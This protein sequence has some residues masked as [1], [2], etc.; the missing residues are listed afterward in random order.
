MSYQNSILFDSSNLYLLR[1]QS[2]IKGP[3]SLSGDFSW[4][5]AFWEVNEL[6]REDRVLI[7][8]WR[9]LGLGGGKGKPPDRRGEAWG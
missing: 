6:Y 2:P 1:V 5:E 3:T 7:L 9:S 4:Q 8:E